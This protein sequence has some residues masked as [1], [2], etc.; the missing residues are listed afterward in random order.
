MVRERV[1]DW[2]LAW[3]FALAGFLA[4]LL[5]IALAQ[6]AVTGGTF[7]AA[8]DRLFPAPKPD[9]QVTLVAIDTPTQNNLGIYPFSNAYHAQVINYLASLHPR[10]ILFDVV[11]DHLTGKELEPPFADTDGPLAKAIKAAGNVVLVCTLDDQP[12]GMF[13]TEAAA[14]GERGLAN[15]DRANAVRGVVLRPDANSTCPQNEADEPAFIQALRIAT[16]ISDPLQINGSAATFGD[17]RIPLVDGQM[18]INFTRGAGS[19][20]SYVDA[21]NSSCPR[22]D[23]ITDH[24]VVVGTKLVDAGDLYS[25]AVAFPHDASFCSRNRPNCMLDTQNFGYRIQADAM[26]TMLDDRYVRVQPDAS[27]RLAIL[28]VGTLVG[29]IVYL[30]SFRLGMILTAS[31]LVVYYLAIYLLGQAGYLS[32]PIYVPMSIVLGAIASLGA[33]YVLE[34]R[35]RRKVEKIFGHYIDPR[36]AQQLAATRSVDD[37]ISKGE[38]RDLTALFMDIRGFTSM[39]ETMRAD[40]VLAVIQVYLDDMSKLILKW[41][42]LIDKYVGDEIMALWNAPLPQANHALLAIRCAYDLLGNAPIVQAKLAAK[43]LPPIGWGIGINTGPAVLGNMGSEDRL[44]YTALGDTVNT[45]ARFCSAAP[46]F[47]V[48]IGW[49]TYEACK[50]F[51]AVDE[52]PGLQLKGKSAETFRI[53]RVTAIREDTS[54]PWV[55]MP[56]E[57]ALAA[58][59]AKRD[60]YAT[61]S[62]FA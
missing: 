35:E 62:V 1:G 56:T 30:L 13:S 12:Q 3:R 49:P 53:L 42:G 50:E 61:Q 52:M 29:L 2:R 38:R 7:D 54:S 48:L 47:Q 41:D 36:V 55:P 11:L 8:Q 46:P 43:G 21:Y 16:G 20:C 17:H 44:Q 57:T 31:I 45:G 18:L 39:S 14:V 40:D 24:I 33:R 26:S 27:I 32:D 22:P 19:T 6:T 15:P 60:L 58:Y 28:L 51:I 37:L 59:T 10:V 9:P 34:E 23:L 4:G 25:Q 5:V